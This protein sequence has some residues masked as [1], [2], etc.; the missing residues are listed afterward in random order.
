MYSHEN[1]SIELV[2]VVL[3][4][5]NLFFCFCIL[6]YLS[7]TGKMESVSAPCVPELGESWL[8]WCTFWGE[9]VH[10]LPWCYVACALYWAPLSPCC[11]R[12]LPISPYLTPLKMWRDPSS[13]L[14]HPFLKYS[15]TDFFSQVVFTNFCWFFLT[16]QRGLEMLHQ[17]ALVLKS[18]CLPFKYETKLK[19]VCFSF[20]FSFWFFLLNCLRLYLSHCNSTWKVSIRA[21]WAR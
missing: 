16:I 11:C 12:K 6:T 14:I 7:I 15:K 17:S 10:M 2:M 8:L 4:V 18:Q 9:S 1:G 5:L 19:T 13:G 20:Q 21:E 3:Q